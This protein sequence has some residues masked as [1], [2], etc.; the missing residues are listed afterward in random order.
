L[1][2]YL[3]DAHWRPLVAKFGYSM[4]FLMVVL[5]RQQL[6]TENTLTVI[7]PFLAKPSWATLRNIARLWTAVLLANLVGALVFAAVISRSAVFEPN[8]KSVFAALGHEAMGAPFGVVVLRGIFAG[9]LIAMMV[10][11]LPFAET[12]RVLVIILVTYLV[13][14]GHFTH[15][16][17]GA[18]DTL[19]LVCMGQLSINAWMT[20]FLI[21]TFVGNVL[22]GV[23]LVAVLNHAQVMSGGGEDI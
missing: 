8:V 22:G 2:A 17:A 19:Y 5:G 14:L 12:S 16:V 4:G 23:P 3:P 20:G 6:F 15:V 11:L 1:R 13:A 9:W 7:L 10:W 21:P 18:V